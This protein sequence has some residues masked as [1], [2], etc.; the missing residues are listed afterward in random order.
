[1]PPCV[2]AAHLTETTGAGPFD[3]LAPILLVVGVVAIG[4]IFTIS[5]R[6]KVA[7][8]QAARPDPEEVVRRMRELR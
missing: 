7:A 5:I 4:V 3:V 6:G 8:R 2:L 1:M